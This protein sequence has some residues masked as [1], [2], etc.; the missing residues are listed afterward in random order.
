MT[1]SLIG[2][3]PARRPGVEKMSMTNDGRTMTQA[4][5]I[6]QSNWLGWQGGACPVATDAL[7]E[8][9]RRYASATIAPAGRLH[10][11]HDQYNAFGADDIIA[12]RIV[13]IAPKGD[14]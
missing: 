14:I 2:N 3:M 11:W 8:V 6:A 5:F 13:T 4:G 7:V 9:M 12:F 10:W 1:R